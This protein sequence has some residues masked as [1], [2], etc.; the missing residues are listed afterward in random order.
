M[1]LGVIIAIISGLLLIL[2]GL[3]LGLYFLITEENTGD[4]GDDGGGK[5]PPPVKPQK[6][7]PPRNITY[8]YLI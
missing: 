8:T 2:L 4:G 6:P 7:G 5:T 1:E 3:A